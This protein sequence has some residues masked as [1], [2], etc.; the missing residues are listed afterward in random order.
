MIAIFKIKGVDTGQEKSKKKTR[1]ILN[2]QRKTPLCKVIDQSSS[3]G[4]WK[5]ATQNPAMIATIAVSN[6][7][8]LSFISIYL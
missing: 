1:S 8:S 3:L 4:I 2:T 6:S 5:T 7:G